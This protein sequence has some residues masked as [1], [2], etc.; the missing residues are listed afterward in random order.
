MEFNFNIEKILGVFP[1]TNIS[2]IDGKRSD[3][4]SQENYS[5]IS[6]LIDKIG[7]LSTKVNNI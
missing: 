3:K 6:D 1:G 7:A 5:K 4:F 2:L